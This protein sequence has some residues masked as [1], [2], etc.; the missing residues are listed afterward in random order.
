[1]ASFKFPLGKGESGESHPECCLSA[2]REVAEQACLGVPE[3]G[4]LL[5]PAYP[6][7][8]LSFPQAL[9]FFEF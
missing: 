8:P 1:M 5:W 7:L 6:G 3:L 2:P 4:S 9:S